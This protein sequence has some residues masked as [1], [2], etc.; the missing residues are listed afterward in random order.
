MRPRRPRSYRRSRRAGPRVFGRRFPPGGERVIIISDLLWRERFGAS[1]SVLGKT[2]RVSA[3]TSGETPKEYRI[4]G[5]L[6]PGFRYV[7]NYIRDPADTALPL[8]TP[9]PAYMVRLR[10]GVPIAFAA[11]R[12]TE[13]VRSVTSEIPA[14]WRGVR[15]E[16]VHAHYVRDVRPV[17]VGV[18]V[19]A[20]L[21]LLIVVINIT[22]LMLLRALRRQKETALRVALGAEPHRIARLLFAEAALIC[23]VALAAGVAVTAITL[24]ALGP[25]IEAR[26]GRPVPGGVST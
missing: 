10:E 13:A 12:I 1:S 4:I 25:Q 20:A 3:A 15:L 18:T 17:L 8:T 24:R 19:A 7:S 11:R 26:L 6:P 14:G 5:V 21:V 2:I 9:R 16:S 23:S 22:V